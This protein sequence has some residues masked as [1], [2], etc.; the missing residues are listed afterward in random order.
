[1][2]CRGLDWTVNSSGIK[3][4]LAVLGAIASFVFALRERLLSGL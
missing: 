3:I 1:M 2:E 4:V